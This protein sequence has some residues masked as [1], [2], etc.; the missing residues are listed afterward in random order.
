MVVHIPIAFS[1]ILFL[2][3]PLEERVVIKPEWRC[4]TLACMKRALATCMAPC[5]LFIQGITAL[6]HPDRDLRHEAFR[7]LRLPALNKSSLAW[8]FRRSTGNRQQR[9]AVQLVNTY[10]NQE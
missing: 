3:R 1:Q 4:W 8:S 5:R 7:A 10:R 2:V 6:V 9:T